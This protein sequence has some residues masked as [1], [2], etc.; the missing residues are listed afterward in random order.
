LAKKAASDVEISERQEEPKI[1]AAQ[2]T[3]KPN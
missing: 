3:T 2:E 1:R